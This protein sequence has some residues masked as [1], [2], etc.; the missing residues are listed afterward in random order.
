M[1]LELAAFNG[2][3][4]LFIVSRCQTRRSET[5]NDVAFDLYMREYP[6]DAGSAKLHQLYGEAILK[7]RKRDPLGPVDTRSP[8]LV[9]IV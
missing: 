2:A 1:A 8:S 3:S 6:V 4:T 5:E 7:K 9:W